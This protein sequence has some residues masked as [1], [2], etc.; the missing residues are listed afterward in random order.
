MPFILALEPDQRQ[1]SLLRNVI[2][3][4]VRAEMVIVESRDAAVAAISARIP[5][6]ILLTALLS[7]R[8]EDQL[9]SHLRTRDGVEHVQ[10]HTLPV[11]ASA[12]LD[13][14]SG[15][16]LLGRFRR[17]KDSAQTVG[18]DPTMFAEEVR[19][20]LAR[21]SELK[22]EAVALTGSTAVL[23]GPQ[24][25]TPPV[26][27]QA[28]AAAREEQ[29]RQARAL[30]ERQRL[31]IE[32]RQRLEFEARQRLEIE[33]RQRLE[34]EERQRVQL[35]ERRRL[36]E[37]QRRQEA[38]EA[39]QRQR[40]LLEAEAAAQRAHEVERL[41]F[42]EERRTHEAL[43]AAER[44]RLVRAAEAAAELARAEER[45]R[46]EE[47]RQQ[48]EAAEAA[49]RERLMREASAAAERERQA[50]RD[51]REEERRRIEAEQAG[52][53]D[54]LMREAAAV[55]ERTL[56]AERE[57][58]EHERRVLEAAQAAER[59]RLTRDAEAAAVRAVEAERQREEEEVRRRAAQ[60][61]AEQERR[62]RTRDDD[63]AAERRTRRERQRPA[64]APVP[65]RRE[66]SAAAP[67]P[68]TPKPVQPREAR[69]DA[70][71]PFADFRA[72]VTGG[73]IDSVLRNVSI[74]AWARPSRPADTTSTE[75]DDTFALLTR[76]RLPVPVSGFAYPRGCRIRRVRVPAAS[77]A[78][79]ATSDPVIVSKRALEEMRTSR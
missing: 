8:D 10:T 74:A 25:D 79:I 55:A 68:A 16:G 60:E 2:A 49:E 71:D 13:E 4:D 48:R 76:L 63:A 73:H 39:A 50:D 9:I 75:Q 31:E 15:G 26:E 33:E 62:L 29:E 35:R 42:E 24:S 54:R 34:V 67:L 40:Q 43:E 36:E 70:N 11:L 47:E 57:R 61:A 27:N 32:E 69:L 56:E 20:Y 66:I 44:E 7:P 5:D 58:M 65:A 21:A 12:I 53:R 6:V 45:Q 41:R 3:A 23:E 59:A 22:A 17:R 51:R 18:C 78:P 37:E 77:E 72:V 38:A 14:P 46:F 28:A 52:E 19:A 64:Q 1:A 30:E